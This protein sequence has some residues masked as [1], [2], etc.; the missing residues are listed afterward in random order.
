M[1][2]PIFSVR[3]LSAAYGKVEAIRSVSLDVHSG[4]IVTVI[5][6]NG[7]G[8]S[9]LLNALMG[10]L[11]AQGSI[12]MEGE[13]QLNRPIAARVSSGMTLVPERRELFGSMTV[14]ENL[15]L[16]AYKLHDKAAMSVE[17]SRTYDQFPRLKERRSQLAGTLSGGERQ[18]LA[19]GRALM[20]RPRLLMLDEPS[21]GLAPKIVAETLQIVVDLKGSGVSTLLVEQ[22]ARAALEIA[23][24][25]YVMELGEVTTNGP[26]RDLLNDNR[27]IASYL[28][29]HAAAANAAMQ[30]AAEKA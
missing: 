24:Y 22:N 3:N 17:L 10:L 8:K 11:P 27:I 29:S 1:K 16:G 9:T 12:R 6:A 28:G 26:A 18:M 23:S 13:E 25:A 19:M 21:L 7:A 4:T 15:E 20:S 30:L 5:G 14:E 2:V